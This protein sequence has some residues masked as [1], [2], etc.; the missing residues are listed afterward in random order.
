LDSTREVSP[1]KKA[2]DAVVL[3]NSELSP[4]EQFEMA[5]RWANE[6]INS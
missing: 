3:D 6:K 1:L 5:L 2:E 4:E